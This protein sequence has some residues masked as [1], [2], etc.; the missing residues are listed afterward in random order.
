MK[1]FISGFAPIIKEYLEFRIAMGRSDCHER[2]LRFFDRFCY[3]RHPEANTLSREIVLDWI[4]YESSKDRDALSYK[5]S[6]IRLFAQY[7]ENGA[8][9][10][11]PS[12][13]LKKSSFTPHIFTVNELTSL[14][15]A[16]DDITPDHGRDPFVCVTAPV[17]FRLIYTCGLRP[18]EGRLLKRKNINLETGEI[19]ITQTKGHRERIVVMSDDMLEMCRQYDFKRGVI[20]GNSE[21]FFVSGNGMELSLGQFSSILKRCWRQANPDTP[22]NFLPRIRPYDLRHQFASAILHKWL[23]EDRDMYAMLPYLRAYMGHEEFKHTAYYIHILP[24]KLLKSPSVDWE[25]LDAVIPEVK[26]WAE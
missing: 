26:I 18:G 6:A 22:D 9:I 12:F 4:S 7:A 1:S 11:A 5:A 23:D 10:L 16:M 17:L 13:A 8:Y 21:Y 20:A 19:L 3:E 2:Y 14:F 25:Q 15:Q 24:E